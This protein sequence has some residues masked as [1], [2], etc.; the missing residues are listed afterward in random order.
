MILSDRLSIATQH[1]VE[2]HNFS[3]CRLVKG[4]DLKEVVGS[5]QCKGVFPGL[6]VVV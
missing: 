1:V 6:L 5:L 4:F 3:M 2:T